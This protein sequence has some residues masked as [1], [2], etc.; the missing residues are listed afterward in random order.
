MSKALSYVKPYSLLAGIALFFMLIE[1]AVEPLQPLLIG[2]IID[3]GILKQD[4]DTVWL[5]GGVMIGLTAVSFASGILNSF[6]SA[7]ISQSYAYDTRKGIF[8]KIQS[9]SY[10][11]FAQFSS[12]SFITRL[13]N[14][15]TQVQ[16]MLFMSLRFMLRAPLMIAGHYSL[17]DRQCE[18]RVFSS[19]HGADFAFVFAV[20]AEKRRRAV[21]VCAKAA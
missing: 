7:H 12:T 4:L 5:W 14:D 16:N 11:T 18:T 21:S 1:L 6:Y 9:F 3:E 19:D 8:Q 2:K 13:T 20:G 17:A 10:S 15:V